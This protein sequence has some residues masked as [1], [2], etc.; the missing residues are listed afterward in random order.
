[1]AIFKIMQNSVPKAIIVLV[2]GLN[3]RPANMEPLGR[4]FLMSQCHVVMVSLKGH[5]EG[6]N[7][8]QTKDVQVEDWLSDLTE[9][10]ETAKQLRGK[11]N[12]PIHFVGFSLGALTYLCM[13]SLLPQG[14]TYVDR[15]VLM[16]PAAFTYIQ[17]GM[18]RPLASLPMQMPIPSFAPSHLKVHDVLPLQFYKN[19]FRMQEIIREKQFRRC[20]LPCL[21]IMNPKDELISLRQLQ[22]DMKKYR[23][24][25]WEVH[26]VS[27]EEKIGRRKW[28]HL[29]A[30]RESLGG[31]EY[32]GMIDKMQIFLN[33][34]SN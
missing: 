2:H 7:F 12:L 15:V 31:K 13:Q 23:L 5:E 16:A 3:N 14:I 26:K 32:Y 6:S 20:N 10:L 34:V 1:M 17:S 24:S 9:G 33:L 29:I 25:E 11:S 19:L 18:F 8:E 22:M 30:L 27:V 28:Q 4:Q 21:L